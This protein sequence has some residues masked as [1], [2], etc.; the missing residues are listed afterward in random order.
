MTRNRFYIELDVHFPLCSYMCISFFNLVTRK[1]LEHL[2]FLVNL[3]GPGVPGYLVRHNL[4]CVRGCFWTLAFESGDR[5][6]QVPSPLGAPYAIRRRPGE[7]E[8]A[9]PSPVREDS[10]HGLQTGTRAVLLTSDTMGFPG[11]RRLPPRLEA[12]PRLFRVRRSLTPHS[13]RGLSASI[14]AQAF[15]SR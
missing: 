3:T 6:R 2:I 13:S 11:V 12:H 8:K 9:D 10:P 7:K 4:G 15:S 14:I 1:K 5:V